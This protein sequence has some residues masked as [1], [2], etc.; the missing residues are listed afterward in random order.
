MARASARLP[1][2]VRGDTHRLIEPHDPHRLKALAYYHR[3]RKRPSWVAVIRHE[4][5]QA[6][7]GMVSVTDNP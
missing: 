1:L 4:I 3:N 7:A 5:E 2:F 6:L